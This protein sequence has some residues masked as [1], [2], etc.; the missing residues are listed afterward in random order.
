MLYFI[1]QIFVY[2]ADKRCPEQQDELIDIV[3]YFRIN[4]HSPPQL[5]K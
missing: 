2:K 3:F 1:G 4:S 5:L